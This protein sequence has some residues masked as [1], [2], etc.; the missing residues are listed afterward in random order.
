MAAEEQLDDRRRGLDR[1]P[2][3]RTLNNRP[4]PPDQRD[5]ALG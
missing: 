2:G 5:Q 3:E 4:Q 1:S